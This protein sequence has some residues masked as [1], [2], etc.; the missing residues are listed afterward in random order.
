VV[1]QTVQ[2][3]KACFDALKATKPEIGVGACQLMGGAIEN[4]WVRQSDKL[5]VLVGTQDQFF[6][7]L[8][9]CN[10]PRKG[11]CTV[12]RLKTVRETTPVGVRALHEHQLT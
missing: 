2:R 6:H 12:L 7:G 10:T 4:E 1:T 3:L 9:G 5:W 11:A 8:S